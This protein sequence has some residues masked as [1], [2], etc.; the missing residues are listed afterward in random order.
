MSG[1]IPR[2][3]PDRLTMPAKPD[4]QV[5]I[6]IANQFLDRD[7]L[8]LDVS[9]DDPVE[10][11]RLLHSAAS[12]LRNLSLALLMARKHDKTS[13]KLQPVTKL[14]TESSG[15]VI[16]YDAH[17]AKIRREVWSAGRFGFFRNLD[18]SATVVTSAEDW[19]KDVEMRDRVLELLRDNTPD[20]LAV[21]LF[22]M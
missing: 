6:M 20:Y 7:L 9:A 19:L 3:N 13:I 14:V 8:A 5:R 18:S 12:R 2:I 22:E 1:E 21:D 4:W 17:S 16:S 11:E 10:S 15:A